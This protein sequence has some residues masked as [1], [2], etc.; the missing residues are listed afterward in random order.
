MRGRIVALPQD[1]LADLLTGSVRFGRCPPEYTA[2]AMPS[3][4]SFSTPSVRHT[5]TR[6][7]SLTWVG[8]P[9]ALP[10]RHIPQARDDEKTLTAAIASLAQN[11]GRRGY[12][13]VAAL[14]LPVGG[15]SARRQM[16]YG[17]IRRD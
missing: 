12:R 4:P 17:G 7:L 6:W 11:C 3:A 13:L 8:P 9:I 5:R 15:L 16:R 1:L 14:V 10:L 2:A